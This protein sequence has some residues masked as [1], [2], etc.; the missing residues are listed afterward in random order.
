MK[1]G[2]GLSIRHL[3][4]SKVN[5]CRKIIP[6]IVKV[7]PPLIHV[8]SVIMGKRAGFYVEEKFTL[9]YERLLSNIFVGNRTHPQFFS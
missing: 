9:D 3:F 8:L 6:K 2:S 7:P 4:R 5:F 1:M